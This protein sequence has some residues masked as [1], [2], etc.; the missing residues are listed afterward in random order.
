MTAL[1]RRHQVAVNYLLIQH[2]EIRQ[3]SSTSLSHLRPESCQEA[4][5]GS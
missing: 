3:L 5:L 2:D 1:G 4:W